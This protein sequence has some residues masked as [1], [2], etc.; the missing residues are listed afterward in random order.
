MI[1]LIPS[2][3]RHTFREVTRT[4]LQFL[5][6]VKKTGSPLSRSVL[7]QCCSK[8]MSVLQFIC[9]LARAQN[10]GRSAVNLFL[11][12]CAEILSSDATVTDQLSITIMPTILDGL[13]ATKRPDMQSAT[14][15]VCG[16]L[17]RKAKLSPEATDTLLR[18]IA[19]YAS[20]GDPAPAILSLA[21]VCHFQRPQELS[22]EAFR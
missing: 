15:M 19:Q 7:A 16:L 5:T 12:A 4:S 17:A 18:M 11:S 6:A 2:L 20:K 10:A 9:N 1:T 8:D 3:L 21:A 22:A 13:R 14:Y